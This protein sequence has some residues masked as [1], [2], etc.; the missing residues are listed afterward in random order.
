MRNPRLLAISGLLK[1][2]LWSAKDGPL[3]MGRDPAN[4]VRADASDAAV[5]RRHCSVMEV[6]SGVFEIA[7]LDSH[8]GTFVNGSKVNRKAIEHG[9][10]I[11]IGKS[12]YLF[13]TGP[14]DAAELVSDDRSRVTS[15]G[16]RTLPLDRS[17]QPSDA[18]G[19]GRMARDLSAFF[20]IANV[21]NSTR[22]LQDLQRE[23]LVLISE[24]IPAAQAAI[25]L[26]SNNEEPSAPCTWS[27]KRPPSRRCTFGRSWCNRR[28]GNAAPLSQ[29]L[30]LRALRQSMCCACPWWRW[31]ESSE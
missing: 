31:R 3:F 15:S 6:S 24:V 5:S 8:N 18:S 1:G 17:G 20:K 28:S 7:D 13:L 26:Q 4:Q 19:V 23:L 29:R 11:R 12:E 14:E 22:D 2:T 25:V 30:R 27:R 9:D 21:I 16:L 10:R